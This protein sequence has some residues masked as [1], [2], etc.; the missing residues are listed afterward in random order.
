MLNDPLLREV[1]MMDAGVAGSWICSNERGDRRRDSRQWQR[2]RIAAEPE[3]AS[4][5]FGPH[6]N[7]PVDEASIADCREADP[8]HDE[9]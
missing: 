9:K 7:Q 2:L 8:D 3:L 6:G 4:N 1:A 5:P